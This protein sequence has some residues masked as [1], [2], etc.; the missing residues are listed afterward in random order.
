MPPKNL[1]K[2][3]R[4]YHLRPNNQSK[5]IKTHIFATENPSIFLDDLKDFHWV[6]GGV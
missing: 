1:L 6:F 4:I 5:N 2:V 3:I